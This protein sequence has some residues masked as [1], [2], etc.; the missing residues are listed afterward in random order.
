MTILA[1]NFWKIIADARIMPAD[2]EKVK[3]GEMTAT[4]LRASSISAH[5]VTIQ[6]IGGVGCDLRAAYGD[7]W[8]DHIIELRS[9]NWTKTN[10]QWENVCIV[11]G[12]VVNNRQS[13][14]SMRAFLGAVCGVPKSEPKLATAGESTPAPSSRIRV[15]SRATKPATVSKPAA[16]VHVRRR[17]KRAA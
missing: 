10:P 4:D 6:A 11:A 16:L 1:V 5:G 3:R 17:G 2:W 7:K 12:S 13:I 14:A 8:V 15:A 9:V